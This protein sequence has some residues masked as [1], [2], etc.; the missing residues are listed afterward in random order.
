MLY[1]I[2][3]HCRKDWSD[4][5]GE[6]E[7]HVSI[8]GWSPGITVEQYQ[9][10]GLSVQQGEPI[11]RLNNLPYPVAIVCL[12]QIIDEGRE[13]GPTDEWGEALHGLAHTIMNKQDGNGYFVTPDGWFVEVKSDRGV[14]TYDE[15]LKA[16][17]G[18]LEENNL[19]SGFNDEY[20]RGGVELIAECF[21]KKDLTF[22]ERM[23]EILAE[24]RQ[25]DTN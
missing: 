22:S 17:R 6:I 2:T 14:A 5:T 24:L 20:V 21:A 23:T 8:D 11:G 16:F 9:S 12:G 15:V 10:I 18:L 3:V 19:E 25:M 4:I 7:Q 13:W 1:T